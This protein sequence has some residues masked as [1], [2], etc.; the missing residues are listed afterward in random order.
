MM[1]L[2]TKLVLNRENGLLKTVLAASSAAFIIQGLGLGLRYTSQVLLARWLGPSEYGAYAYIFSW[3]QIFALLS[4]LGFTISLL[5][6]IPEHQTKGEWLYLRGIIG[7]SRQIVLGFGVLATAVC[8]LMLRL[9][10][11]TDIPVWTI[12]IG[13]LV[14][15]VYGLLQMQTE[16]IRSLRHISAAYFIPMIAQPILHLGLILVFLRI[17]FALNSTFAFAALL[18]SSFPLLL[19]QDWAIRRFMPQAAWG[20]RP[21]FQMVFWLSVSLPLLYIAAMAMIQDQAGIL[22]VGSFLGSI[23]A[24]VYVAALKTAVLVS[25]VLIAVNTIAAPMISAAYTKQDKAE[26]QQIVRLANLLTFIF[27]FA[28]GL[29]LILIGK[30]VLRLFGPGF[31]EGYNL[32]IVFVI[33]QWINASAGPVGYLV[34]LTGHQRDAL[35]VYTVSVAVNFS[36]MLLL[37]PTFGLIGAAIGTA[38]SII[39]SNVWLSIIARRRLGINTFLFLITTK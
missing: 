36:A 1:T 35:A 18:V 19:V 12:L 27:S 21:E 38:T 11:P 15:P 28:A 4:G 5:R 13:S 3:I 17:I 37:M 22:V 29:C 26:L 20:V 23:K 16:I 30:S 10:K 34:I 31:E 24:G 9:L 6:F 32:L 14:I 39:L 33:G 25:F 2:K 8:F 7:R